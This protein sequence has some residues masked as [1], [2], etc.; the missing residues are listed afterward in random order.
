[1][2]RGPLSIAIN[3]LVLQFYH[4]G[5]WD[6]ILPCSNKSLDHG[7]L[8]DISSSLYTHT[9]VTYCFSSY[10]YNIAVLLVG[11]GTHQ[12]LFGSKPYWLV[13]NSWGE[14]WGLQGYFMMIRGKGEC[15][16]DQQVT[17]AVLESY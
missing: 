10:V 12:G 5:V 17:S 15:G 2:Q 11:Y 14:K 4:S 6:P 1:M 9:V 7:N 3:A 8:M 16:M 13:K